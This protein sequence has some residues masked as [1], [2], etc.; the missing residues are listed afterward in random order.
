MTVL[1]IFVIMLM[2]F[3][4]PCDPMPLSF[5]PW[6]IRSISLE[7]IGSNC[8]LTSSLAS[9]IQKWNILIPGRENDQAPE[10]VLS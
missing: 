8:M 4:I 6:E 5:R 1:L 2:L 10:P 9:V 7:L 3:V